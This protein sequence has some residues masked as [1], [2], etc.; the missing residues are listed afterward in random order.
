MVQKLET[1]VE[2][3]S[4][5]WADPAHGKEFWCGE[6]K[7]NGYTIVSRPEAQSREEMVTML[8]KALLQ[9]FPDADPAKIIQ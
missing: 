7:L 3:T 2:I 4:D 6:L 9:R 5:V 1:T 8:T